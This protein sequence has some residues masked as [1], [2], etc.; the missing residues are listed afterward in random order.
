MFS[1]TFRVSSANVFDLDKANILS[2]GEGLT[3]EKS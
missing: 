1:V 3:T 2:S